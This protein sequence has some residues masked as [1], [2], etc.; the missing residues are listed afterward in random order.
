MLWLSGEV[1]VK[2]YAQYAERWRQDEIRALAE[3][4]ERAAELA[5]AKAAIFEQL[6]RDMEQ[7]IAEHAA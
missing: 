3:S 5:R 4:D 1:L 2:H 6:G 7:Q